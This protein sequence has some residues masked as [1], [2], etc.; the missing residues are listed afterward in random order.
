MIAAFSPKRLKFLGKAELFKNKLFAC[1]LRS[2]GCV[3]VDR[4]GGDL[5]A[6]RTC[7]RILKENN[8]LMLF[9]EGTRSCIHIDDVDGLIKKEF[10]RV[11]L[12]AT[13]ALLSSVSSQQGESIPSI[14]HAVHL[15]RI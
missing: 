4:S 8:P 10:D 7:I 3:P 11:L 1:V 6:M 9:P 13:G 12:V 5:K 14:A 15:I 2:I